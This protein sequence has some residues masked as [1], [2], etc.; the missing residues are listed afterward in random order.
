MHNVALLSISLG[1]ALELKKYDLKNLELAAEYH[2]IGKKLIDPKILFVNR[3]LNKEEFE[4][5]KTHSDL[6]ACLLR[7]YGFDSDIVEAV[8]HHH[9]RWDGSGYPEGLNGER[10]PLLARI[11]A[12]ADA[13]EAMTSGRPYKGAISPAKA[14]NELLRCAGSQFDPE[15]VEL[16]ANIQREVKMHV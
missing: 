4:I 10:I 8:R 14:V 3:R 12:V 16:F 15:L 9:E 6:G 2:D 7:K 13:Y 5:V 1:K 11:I